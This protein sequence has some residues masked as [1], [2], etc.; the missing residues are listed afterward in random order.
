MVLFVKRLCS[1]SPFSV[2]VHNAAF[3]LTMQV[4]MS[5]LFQI[6]R[7]RSVL[8]TELVF[9]GLFEF[10]LLSLAVIIS[11][12]AL[13]LLTYRVFQTKSVEVGRRQIKMQRSRGIASFNTFIL[14]KI[15]NLSSC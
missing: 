14:F 2:Y 6:S 1:T 10:A 13:R 5:S 11:Y 8:S 7:P 9:H 4:G 3:N 12:A 15:S